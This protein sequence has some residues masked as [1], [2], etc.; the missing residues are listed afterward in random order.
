MHHGG[1]NEPDL[2]RHATRRTPF[3]LDCIEAN[4]KWGV[5]TKKTRLFS[6]LL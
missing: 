4:R 2:V 3:A 5:F 1:A 6:L